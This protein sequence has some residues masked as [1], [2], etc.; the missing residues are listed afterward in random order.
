VQSAETEQSEASDKQPNI[1]PTPTTITSIM[2][3]FSSL[4]DEDKTTVL[5]TLFKSMIGDLSEADFIELSLKAMN[6]LHKYG[7]SN[8]LYKLASSLA[9][10]RSDNTDS[11]LPIH[12]MPFGLIE[13][14]ISFFYA[15]SV[16]VVGYQ[17]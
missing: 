6:R 13:Y 11:R 8:V 14:V 17:S 7:H 2:E 1:T 9:T 12:R 16:E 3:Q 15:D 10:M 4:T 5:G